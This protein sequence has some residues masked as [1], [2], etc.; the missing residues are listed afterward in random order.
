MS[1]GLILEGPDGVFQLYRRLTNTT[2]GSNLEKFG[3]FNS[4][5]D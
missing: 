3:A 4:I 2:T 5:G 1:V